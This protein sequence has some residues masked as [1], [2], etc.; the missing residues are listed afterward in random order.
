MIQL[1][2]IRYEIGTR[3]LL[4]DVTW[5]IEP[6]K[7]YALVGINGAGKTTL[8]RVLTGEIQPHSGQVIKGRDDRI[9]YLAQE[10]VAASE[11]T[12]IDSV[13][14]FRRDLVELQRLMQ[15]MRDQLERLPQK[16]AEVL[17]KLG[18]LEHQFEAA[19]GYRW[20]SEAR[21][22]LVG[23]GFR[24]D[25]FDR[26]LSELSGGWRMRALLAGLLL[27]APDLLLLDEPTNHLDLEA[28]EWLERFLQGYRGSI[29]LVSHDRF[30]IDRLAQEIVELDRGG[31]FRYS[32]DYRAFVE[33]KQNRQELLVKRNKEI[34]AE[35][36]HLQKFIDRFRYKATKA[37]QVQSRIKRLE[38]LEQV[39]VAPPESRL[40]FRLGVDKPGHKQVVESENLWF[41]YEHDWILRDIDFQLFRGQKAA[42]VGVNGAGKTTFTRLICGE[43]SPQ[44][45]QLTLGTHTVIGYYAQH[46]ADALNL[47]ATVYEEIAASVSSGNF[48]RIRDVLG[49]FQFHGDD[50]YKPIS[51]LSGGE[52]ARVSLARI[53]LSPANFLI[54]DEP[55]NHLDIRSREAL[56]E[57]L[58]QY[59]GT[60]LLISHDRYFLDRIVSRVVEIK[61]G[62]LSVFEGNYSDYLRRRE[63]LLASSELDSKPSVSAATPG[64][65]NKEQ[66]RLEAQKRQSV[67]ADRRLLEQTIVDLERA[68][69]RLE[70]EKVELENRLADPRTYQS[71]EEA[72]AVQREYNR[73]KQELADCL[74]R[75]EENSLNL[76]ALLNSLRVSDG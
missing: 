64:K 63:E 70:M 76:D 75:W 54:M 10:I 47:D 32:G 16:S 8:L 7:H 71:G 3:V 26:P 14:K 66:K 33:E 9:G 72:A 52:K 50:V 43:L 40:S 42:L 39:E 59:D 22:I 60:L 2:T 53:L 57:A 68:I 37:A 28:L 18:D 30:F 20:E 38:K 6:G 51:V 11:G 65:K 48:P 56:E 29:I 25:E 19:G 36:E 69:E 15:H 17:H 35:K 58:L 49:I 34:E 62:Q 1:F 5:A 24:A 55:T 46:Q 12:V 74:S 73:V 45:G 31:I 21:E 27:Q 41:R 67:S 13:L 23:L 44:Q 4:D 61:E